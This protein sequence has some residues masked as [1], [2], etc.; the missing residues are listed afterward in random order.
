MTHLNRLM[1][2]HEKVFNLRA[3]AVKDKQWCKMVQ[4]NRLLSEIRFELDR[5]QKL[6]LNMCVEYQID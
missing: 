2:R 1:L 6:P 4:A 3:N 5:L